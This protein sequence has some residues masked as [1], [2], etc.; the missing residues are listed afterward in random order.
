[1]KCGLALVAPRQKPT[2]GKRMP[3]KKH[4]HEP[5]APHTFY[6]W[7]EEVANGITHGIGVGL[8]GVGVIWLVSM[9]L[10]RGD[11]WQVTGFAVYGASLIILYLAS[12]LYHTIQYPPIKPILQIVDHAAVYILIAGTY[13][14][15][16]LI[17]LRGPFGWSLL[18]FI[19]AL[20]GTGI[21]FKTFFINRFEAFST[22]AYVLMGWMSMLAYRQLLAHI[23]RAGFI[24]LLVGGVFYTAGVGFYAWERLPFNHAIWHLFVLGGSACHYLAIYSL[25]PAV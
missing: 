10:R 25:L 12:T 13:T 17:S 24:W 5:K 4:W 18:A 19:W 21:L 1:M 7:G 23:P 16:L 2:P 20:A 22:I 8:S 11:S 3:L 9:A 14:P 6:T 15:F